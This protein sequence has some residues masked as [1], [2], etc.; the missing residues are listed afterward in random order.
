[1]AVEAK[2]AFRL[3]VCAFS[4]AVTACLSLTFHSTI[5]KELH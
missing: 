4:F 1:M 2:E 3:L 5:L